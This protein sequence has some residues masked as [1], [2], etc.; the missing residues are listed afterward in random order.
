[1]ARWQAGGPLHRRRTERRLLKTVLVAVGPAKSPSR[2]EM[3]LICATLCC[4]F[5]HRGSV[6]CACQNATTIRI[7]RAHATVSTQRRA[8]RFRRLRARL[9]PGR[10][11]M[12]LE[13]LAAEGSGQ[14]GCA[15]ES[16]LQSVE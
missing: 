11:A 2:S 9:E 8:D 4:K 5:A 14:L 7:S 1:M 13:H 6:D 3:A 15:Y 10:V 16:G 12:L